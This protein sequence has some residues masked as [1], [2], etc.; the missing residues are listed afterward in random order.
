[1]ADE[2]A[3]TASGRREDREGRGGWGL[4]RGERWEGMVRGE[5]WVGIGERERWEG[6]VRGER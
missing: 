1:M 3:S 4:V 5:R 6:I 2:P